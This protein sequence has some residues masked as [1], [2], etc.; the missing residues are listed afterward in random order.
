MALGLALSKNALSVDLELVLNAPRVDGLT[1]VFSPASTEGGDVTVN[2]QLRYDA[3][4]RII[5]AGA[6]TV[7]GSPVA[8]K[9]SLSSRRGVWLYKLGLTGTAEKASLKVKG[10]VRG[11]KATIKYR[12]PKGKALLIDQ[13]VTL[14]AS[15]EG[16][17][18]KISLSPE[19]GPKG[20]ITGTASII[21]GY[22]NDTGVS[23]ALKGKLKKERLSFS[24][25]SG[26]Q[27]V[28]F[29]G[30]RSGDGYVGNLKVKL[31]PEK[32]VQRNFFVPNIFKE[33]EPPPGPTSGLATLKGQ[34]LLLGSSLPLPGIG[35]TVRAI[36]DS[37]GN[38]SL[39][40]DE[41]VLNAAGLD[42]KYEIQLQVVS[43]REVFLEFSLI[44]HGTAIKALSSVT[45]GS[46]IVVDATLKELSELA[47]KNG[48]AA[49]TD[50][51]LKVANLPPQVGR[52][53]GRVFDPKTETGQFPG[54]FQD[55]GGR[56]LISSV[57]AF[58]EAR[59]GS[60]NEIRELGQEATLRMEVPRDAWGTLRDLAA[61]NG[62]IDVPF[63][64]MDES[65]FEWK[66]SAADGWLEDAQGERIPES[67][68]S[69]LQ[70]GSFAGSV[71]AAGHITH[72]SYWNVDWPVETHACVQ[73]QVFDPEGN[74]VA[75]AKVEV[76]GINYSGSTATAT[77][78]DGRFCAEV[79][80]SEEP[81]ED[82]DGDGVP[83][84]SQ[85]IRVL[86]TASEGSFYSFG[87]FST[88]IGQG[89]CQNGSCRELSSFS[90]SPEH[91]LEVKL[92][93][94]TG[95]VVYSGKATGGSPQLTQDDPIAGIPV[96]AVDPAAQ[97]ELL[98]CLSSAAC[99]AFTVSGP[100][101]RFTL[102][103]PILSGVQ[104]LASGFKTSSNSSTETYIGLVSLSECPAGPV[105]LPVDF[106]RTASLLASLSND[107]GGLEG[108]LIVS[109]DVAT[110]TLHLGGEVLV[111]IDA[112]GTD[113][114]P[115]QKL[116]LWLQMDLFLASAADGSSK[117]G[118][119]SFSVDRTDSPVSGTWEATD[120]SGGRLAGGTWAEEGGQ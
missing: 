110:C 7:D 8:V 68:C 25:S 20:N 104:L 11:G 70:D 37:N 31:P 94:I 63:F 44:E 97:K 91:R 33:E 42:G 119:I 92:C 107:A 58:L 43:G 4:G 41:P 71:F 82:V 29:K 102:S 32:S 36:T 60:G 22:G 28:S 64:S 69:C 1:T 101:G 53:T 9:G 49:T 108:N 83:G 23:G 40:D 55:N 67:D 87:P 21:S 103:V 116:G 75:G 6:C 34:V 66:R 51:R 76:D 59:D 109:T 62:Q 77:G 13:P 89:T 26:P 86:V 46:T 90:L 114:I 111:G 38:G 3:K 80:R 45:P 99:S 96:V 117:V 72:L 18:G 5:C 35:V 16:L 100:D 56:F 106:H 84:E 10:E 15:A 50:G 81:G 74:P 54:E 12:G 19:R 78:S 52:I 88:A 118:T 113:D 47:V 2:L 27:K 48:V 105:S 14:V 95:T 61:G 39:S 120:S 17:A 85:A 115:P 73:G 24:F 30:S 65:S 112:S 57:F 98:S 93:A 79:L